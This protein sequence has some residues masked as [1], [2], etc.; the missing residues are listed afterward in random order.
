MTRPL[1]P[2]ISA[3]RRPR[4]SRSTQLVDDIVEAAIRVLERD[5][6]LKFSTIR[7]AAE[8]GVSVGSLYQY[9]PNKAALLFRLQADEWEETWSVVDDI[10]RDRTEPP[11]ARLRRGVLAFFR[12]ERKEA[13]LRLAL[14]ASGALLHDAPEARALFARATTSLTEFL[15]E[16][17]PSATPAQRA[18]ASELVMATMGSVA[19]KVTD[20]GRTR[21]DVDAWAKETAAMLCAYI[22]TL[23]A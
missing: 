20:Q 13:N 11:L 6:G 16:A 4:Q 3:R 8:A 10:L 5:G 7:V 2:T 23:A 17:A 18:F 9:F 22:D 19:E 1:P 15:R 21:L 12:S 14:N